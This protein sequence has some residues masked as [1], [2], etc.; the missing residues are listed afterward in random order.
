MTTQ[1]SIA[2]FEVQAFESGYSDA[3]ESKLYKPQSI[4]KSTREHI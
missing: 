3:K 2:L 4:T 1:E